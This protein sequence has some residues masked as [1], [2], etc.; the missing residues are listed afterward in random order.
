MLMKKY[1]VSVIK[2]IEMSTI[3]DGLFLKLQNREMRN[4]VITGN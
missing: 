2:K 1:D 3:W 4:E